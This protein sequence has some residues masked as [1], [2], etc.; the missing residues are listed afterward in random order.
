MRA[1]ALVSTSLLPLS[2]L[3]PPLADSGEREC[4]GR[5]PRRAPWPGASGDVSRA[6]GT[7]LRVSPGLGPSAAPRTGRASSS[8][9]LRLAEPARPFGRAGAVSLDLSPRA[10]WGHV[11]PAV[12]PGPRLGRQR[13][14]KEEDLAGRWRCPGFQ[15]LP[16]LTLLQMRKLRRRVSPLLEVV[17]LGARGRLKCLA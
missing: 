4:A 11:R 17:E 12:Q 7:L 15:A 5:P 13:P 8:Q 16:S 10:P 3:E 14:F 9:V 6:A 1:R 2:R